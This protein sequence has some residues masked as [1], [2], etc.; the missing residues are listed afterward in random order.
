MKTN[1]WQI[2]EAK[3]HFSEVVS[4]ASSQGVQ[5]I[6]KHGKPVAVVVAIEEFQSLKSRTAK[7]KKSLV[8][9]LQSCPAP[10]VFEHVA[11]SRKRR[12]YGRTVELD[13]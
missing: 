11:R 5:T 4:Q 6:T 7:K 10:E 2:Q 3:N 13:E 8:E 12:D 1:T 9:V